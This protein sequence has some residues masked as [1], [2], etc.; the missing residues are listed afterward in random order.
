MLELF[1][2]SDKLKNINYGVGF[3][4]RSGRIETAMDCVLVATK[5]MIIADCIFG[6]LLSCDELTDFLGRIDRKFHS[7]FKY[8]EISRIIIN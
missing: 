3:I 7:G 5:R 6:Y 2:V 4:G 8:N 1:G